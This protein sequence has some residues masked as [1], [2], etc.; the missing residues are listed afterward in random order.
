[1]TS[2]LWLKSLPRSPI[3]KCSYKQNYW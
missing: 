2:W 1:M 3:K